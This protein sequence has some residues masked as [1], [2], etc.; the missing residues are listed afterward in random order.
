MEK[1]FLDEIYSEALELVMAGNL[2]GYLSF[3]VT[4]CAFFVS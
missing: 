2:Q 3:F 4:W 1:H